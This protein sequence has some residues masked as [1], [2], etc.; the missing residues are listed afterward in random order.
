MSLSPNIGTVH[1]RISNIMSGGKKLGCETCWSG[2]NTRFPGSLGD[3]YAKKYNYTTVPGRFHGWRT[4][5]DI[6]NTIINEYEED[7]KD[8][9]KFERK[10]PDEDEV[11]VHLRMGDV[12]GTS[13]PDHGDFIYKDVTI[14]IISTHV[15]TIDHYKK[16]VIDIRKYGLKNVT[17]IGNMFHKHA[18]N[19]ECLEHNIKY[20]ECMTDFFKSEG[21][22]VNVLVENEYNPLSL[23]YE[24]VDREF[25]YMT[26]SKY[27][28]PSAS[29][30]GTTFSHLI[31]KIVLKRGGIVF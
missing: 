18:E 25:I 27:Y 22:E 13:R 4:N 16:K 2:I 23:H 9:L 14:P 3:R 26:K 17:I 29:P 10:F 15:H 11:I 19:P 24:N 21:F 5:I 20:L 7:N 8:T 12:I 31:G 6:I 1:Y 28:M 30:I